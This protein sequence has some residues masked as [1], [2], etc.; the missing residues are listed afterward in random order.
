MTERL[1]NTS[2]HDSQFVILRHEL[3][4]IPEEQGPSLRSAPAHFDW[5][6]QVGESL[7]TWSTTPVA[8]LDRDLNLDAIQL[9]NHRCAYL[10]IQGEISGGRGSVTRLVRGQLSHLVVS[11]DS[12]QAD[13]LWPQTSE[14]TLQRHLTIQRIA[15]S[16]SW[17]LRLD[18]GLYD[19]NR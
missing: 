11:D 13:L 19:T 12:C 9:P 18:C 2:P 1:E 15:L 6:L 5:M 8:D 14:R 17:R 7:L 3:A 10:E 4:T 16:D